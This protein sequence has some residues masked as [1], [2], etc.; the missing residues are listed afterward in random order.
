MN[1]QQSYF[2]NHNR[3]SR[4]PWS[5]YHKPLLNSLEKFLRNFNHAKNKKILVIGPG[6]LQELDL[7]LHYG[8]KPS[9]LDIDERTLEN[10]KKLHPNSIENFYHVDEKFNGYPEDEKFD[11]VYAKEVIEHITESHSFFCKVKSTLR[12]DGRIWLSTPNYGFFLLP[13]LEKTILELIARLSGFSRKDIHPNKF[14]QK[15]MLETLQNEGF[16]E[17]K[18]EVTFASLALCGTGKI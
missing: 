9:L 12:P 6:D 16:K 4:F 17:V 15:K 1:N 3:A 18:I 11:A 8:F 13:L 10:L 5:I 7:L 2:T 14:N